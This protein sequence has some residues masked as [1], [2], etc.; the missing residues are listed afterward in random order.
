[1]DPDEV[2]RGRA[3]LGRR[4][5]ALREAAGFTQHTFAPLVFYGRSTIANVETGGQR[6][7][8]EFWQ[9]CDQVL[10]TGGSLTAEY[11]GLEALAQR[12]RTERASQRHPRDVGG[13]AWVR[14]PSAER[15]GEVERSIMLAARETSEHA[16]NAGAW[17][18]S[19]ATI[20]Q[21]SD[22]A[23]RIAREFGGLPPATAVSET[24][25]VRDLAVG[26]LDRTRRPAQHSELYL[27]IAQAAALLASESIDLGLWVEAMRYAR[28]ADTYGEVIGHN[29]VRCYSRTLQATIAYWTGRP[30]EAVAHAAVAV[31]LAP[32]G[33]ARVRAQCVLA[34]AWAHQGAE[35]EV[36]AAVG[37]A[38]DARADQGSDELHDVV[39]GEFGFSSAQQARCDG[40]AWL[41]V[42]HPIE[43]IEAARRALALVA[44]DSSSA[45][46]STV[47]AEARVDLAT[48]LVLAGDVDA[49]PET[50]AP[51]WQ[52]PA[53]WRRAGL[54]GRVE[55]VLTVLGTGPWH[56]ATPALQVAELG[57]AFLATRAALPPA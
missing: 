39:G 36:R 28:A 2:R 46:W 18:V 42:Q 15:Y 7:P 11:E 13:G 27:V 57:E 33:V 21:L 25:R 45:P 23:A 50:L 30:G 22:D 35:E 32:V 24:L 3:V 26:L 41:Q 49:V 29:G 37:A 8:R 4:L 52:M 9:R 12:L 40:T 31:S 10:R 44:H 19:E 17:A 48:C 56:A 6:V 54:L 34:R 20:E 53:P 43:A 38:H 47:E 1:M 14:R 5:A 55:K 51:L 16:M